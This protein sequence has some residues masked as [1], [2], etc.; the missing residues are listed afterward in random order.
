MSLDLTLM[1]FA[2]VA[3]HCHFSNTVLRCQTNCRDLFE[4]IGA[5]ITH[6]TT[7]SVEYVNKMAETKPQRGLVPKNFA[8]YKAKIPDGTM[9]GEEYYGEV[10]EDAYGNPLPYLTVRI[11]LKFKNHP[12]V[13]RHKIH[14]AIWAYLEHL[15]LDTKVAIFFH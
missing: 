1:P 6:T 8:C 4:E 7:H 3:D 13:L 2:G 12:G 10:Q 11:L 15:D 9:E 14:Q 5:E